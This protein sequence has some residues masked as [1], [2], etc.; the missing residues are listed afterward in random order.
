MLNLGTLGGTRSLAYGINNAGHV[1][2]Q[3]KVP[4]GPW[5]AFD[6]SL[7]SGM[8]DLG[9]PGGTTNSVARGLNNAGQIAGFADNGGG[10]YSAH[11]KVSGSWQTLPTLGGTYSQA[12]AVNDA[13]RI[14]GDAALPGNSQRNAALWNGGQ[15]TNLGRIPGRNLAVGLDI[16]DADQVVG[17]S[18]NTWDVDGHAFHWSNGVMTDLGTLGG[19]ASR[20]N[21]INLAGLATGGSHTSANQ[22]HGF[23][24]AE[25]ALHDLNDL[26]VPGADCEV[27]EGM[28]IN[29]TGQIV[30]NGIV[31]GQVHAVLLTPI[32]EPHSLALMLLGASAALRKCTPRVARASRP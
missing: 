1:V 11:T 19:S 8:S 14:V 9:T 30:A 12:Q 16:N 27:T 29:A 2:G 6:W 7:G 31:D 22:W 17:W 4:S 20:A 3:A 10:N 26:L 18:G 24:Y 13:G 15:V 28:G 32:P 21:A 25:G 5:R 23:L